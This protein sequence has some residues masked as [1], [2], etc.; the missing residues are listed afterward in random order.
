HLF[1][2]T[3]PLSTSNTKLIYH[4]RLRTANRRQLTT[5]GLS[6]SCLQVYPSLSRSQTNMTSIFNSAALTRRPMIAQCGTAA[7]LFGAGDVIAQQAIEKK[8]LK[9]HD[10]R[11][12]LPSF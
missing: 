12:H 4:Y 6:P 2:T 8:G 7:V 10:V 11:L 9:G 3:Y 1:R 5:D